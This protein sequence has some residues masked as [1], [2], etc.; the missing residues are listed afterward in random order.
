MKFVAVFFLRAYKYA[1]S[2]LLPPAC[3][4]TPTCSEYAAEAIAKYG[5]L[6]G[7]ALGIRRLSR[8]HPFSE[9]GYDPVR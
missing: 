4:F 9:G 1:I 8:C 5:F 7:S 3:R 2:P 6:K